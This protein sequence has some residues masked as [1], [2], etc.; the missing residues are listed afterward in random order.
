MRRGRVVKEFK[1]EDTTEAEL[2]R[3]LVAV[4]HNHEALRD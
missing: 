2:D 3:E 4:S 1:R